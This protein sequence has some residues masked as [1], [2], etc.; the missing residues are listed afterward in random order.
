MLKW[1]MLSS[2]IFIWL[3]YYLAVSNYKPLS[4]QI[5]LKTMQIKPQYITKTWSE[6][7]W[8]CRNYSSSNSSY[9]SWWWWSST[10][11]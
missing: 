4:K 11:K 3:W 10:W 7:V 2:I 9:S 8:D 5:D 1:I 6:C